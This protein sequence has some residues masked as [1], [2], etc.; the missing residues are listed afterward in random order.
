MSGG[1]R[2]DRCSSQSLGEDRS[3]VLGVRY[4]QIAKVT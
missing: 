4:S 1:S 2:F 3:D